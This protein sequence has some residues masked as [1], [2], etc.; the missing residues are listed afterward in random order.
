MLDPEKFYRLEIE[1]K[2]I[3]CL[4]CPRHSRYVE[5]GYLVVSCRKCRFIVVIPRPR[6]GGS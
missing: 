5:A 3:D 4:P 2:T 1:G 6:A